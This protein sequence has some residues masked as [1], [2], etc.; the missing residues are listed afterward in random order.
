MDERWVLEGVE[1]PH[2]LALVAAP[3]RLAGQERPLAVLVSET[4]NSGSQLHKFIL[5]PEGTSPPP[6]LQASLTL[7][8]LCCF[9][10]QQ[11]LS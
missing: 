6:L 2:D 4:R 3:L 1:S 5:M 10:L 7:H 9:Y 11:K 8:A